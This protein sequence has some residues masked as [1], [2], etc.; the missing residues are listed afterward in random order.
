ML[1]IDKK[2]PV[3]FTDNALKEIQRLAKLEAEDKAL[4]L[5]VKNG[6]CSGFTYIFEF[7]AIVQPVDV[8]LHLLNF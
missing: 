6:G 5:G 3:S 2:I 4:C 1:V 7:K 8:A